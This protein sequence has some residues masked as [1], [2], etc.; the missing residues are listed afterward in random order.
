MF[1]I[2][3]TAVAV[4]ALCASILTPEVGKFTLLN[5]VFSILVMIAAVVMLIKALIVLV[6]S[7][8]I[9]SALLLM[10]VV[11]IV[12]VVVGSKTIKTAKDITSGP[13]WIIIPNCDLE[14]RST[15]SGIF[16]LNYYLKG[17]DSDGNSY[18]FSLSGEEYNT[19]NGVDE[20]SVLCYRNTGRVVEIKR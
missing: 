7:R 20:V 10:A 19:L 9:S 15:S 17:V 13:E 11:L 16:G 3:L 2:V 8:K 12:G 4:V 1:Y 6:K 5:E 14:R 18:R